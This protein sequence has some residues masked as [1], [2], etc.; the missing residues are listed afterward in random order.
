MKIRSFS[1]E[2]FKSL[3]N[4]TVNECSDFHA[5][6][7]ANSAGKTS[8]FDA[9]NLI[10]LIGKNFPNPQL[11]TK[12]LHDFEKKSIVVDLHIDLDDHER[13]NYL[14][15]SFHIVENKIDEL[16]L[17]DALR[18]IHLK[19]TIF[20]YGD[21]T[22]NR[23][24]EYIVFPSLL[25]I[26]TDAENI[27]IVNF[28]GTNI[29]FKGQTTL[30]N[31]LHKRTFS[32]YLNN[33]GSSGISPNGEQYMQENLFSGRFLLDFISNMRYIEAIRETHKKVPISYFDQEASIG[34]RGEQLANFMDTLWTNK[35]EQ[36]LEIEKYCK[37]I[38]PN[39]EKIR[40]KKLPDN[41]IILEVHKKNIEKPLTLDSD[42]RGLDQA[43]VV[44]WRMATSPENTIW[45]VDEPEIHLH[46][47]AQK[48]LY[49]F[50]QNEISKNKQIFVST[51]SMV[52]IHRCKEE[53]ISILLYKDGVT[54]LSSLQNLVNVE[55]TEEINQD[56]ARDIVYN[57]LGYDS[58]QSL[59]Y[60][61][62]V[63][64]EGKTDERILKIFANVL[65]TPID[66]RLVKFIPV[67]NKNDAKRFTPILKYTVSKKMIIILDND[68]QNPKE[69]KQSIQN[70]ES[71]YKKKIGIE[72]SLLKD[73]DFCFYDK[74]VYS[75]ESYLLDAEA[76]GKAGSLENNKIEEIRKRIADDQVK[77]KKDREKPKTLLS[78]IWSDF[79]LGN[80]ND[81]SPEKIA[82][83]MSKFSLL[84]FPEISEIINKIN[85]D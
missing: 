13:R 64:V 16:L 45:L 31:D 73:E 8:I 50:F 27:T 80:Y 79:G 40:P 28:D 25:E 33:V 3:E 76:I 54:E 7:G 84:K 53:Q 10:K 41:E 39:I 72:K 82:K 44:I 36:Y 65:E 26:T 21:K 19:I 6:I 81:E 1:I 49:E 60:T 29:T 30:D 18:E 77:Q 55:T 47:G 69:L 32:N 42:G 15:H 56:Q 37:V 75:I 63:A 2:N 4:V 43:L 9:L 85:G 83:N 68:N 58:S 11:V 70:Q 22:T 59:E 57:A 74:N 12:G 66:E 61:T 35:N 46:P 14:S 34:Q 62:I 51:H 17:T 52:F 24:A 78:N 67:G 20:L 5:L 23:I 38:F 71:E 48:L